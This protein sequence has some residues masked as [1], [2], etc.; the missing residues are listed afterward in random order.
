MP[1]R[2]TIQVL[3]PAGVRQTVDLRLHG[4]AVVR[5]AGLWVGLEVVTD[6]GES[7]AVV[8]VDSERVVVRI[9]TDFEMP[10][11]GLST[12][13]P[14]PPLVQEP[15]MQRYEACAALACARADDLDRIRIHSLRSRL[16]IDARVAAEIGP[17]LDEVGMTWPLESEVTPRF[18]EGLEEIRVVEEKHQHLAYQL[19]EQLYYWREDVRPRVI[20]KFDGI[21]EW[22]LPHAGRLL[23]VASKLA[24]ATIA[25]VI[26]G[27][28][29]RFFAG[30]AIEDRV[31]SLEREER[32][33]P[34]SARDE[35]RA[36]LSLGLAVQHEYPRD[37][38]Q[39]RTV[40]DRLLLHG[41]LDL[42]REHPSF[43]PD[44]GRGAG[45]DRPA[46]FTERPQVDADL[47]DGTWYRSGIRAVRAAVA[48]GV[49]ITYEIHYNDAIA[50][51]GGQPVD[52][53]LSVPSLVRQLLA[54]DVSEVAVA[55]H[56]PEALVGLRSG[57]ESRPRDEPWN[58]LIAGVGRTGVWSP[59]VRSRRWRRSST[60]RG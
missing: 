53:P 12:R 8:R 36:A 25:K 21:G 50:T 38:G 3:S 9:P 2:R 24:P 23:P 52:A 58:I 54:E 15:R 42:R 51:T 49:R 29:R 48:A 34:R 60:A 20:G 43:Q 46:P 41:E 17:R 13:W 5:F 10:E 39:F 16:G 18:A 59:S 45:P 30:E 57:V 19:E 22:A 32:P 7:T 6:R 33:R 26:A 11:G 27:R 55:S 31:R 1:S 40:R 44:R 35:A 47:G 37:R 4:W 28:I 14:D 56:E